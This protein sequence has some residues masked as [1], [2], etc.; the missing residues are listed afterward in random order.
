MDY[1][2]SQKTLRGSLKIMGIFVILIVVEAGFYRY[3]QMLKLIKLC[4]KYVPICSSIK[5]LL[6]M[7]NHFI[8]QEY[9]TGQG[10]NHGLQGHRK[11]S[12]STNPPLP[13][14]PP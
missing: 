5:L 9:N 10:N 6:K 13:N 14:A 11:R 7:K 8:F 4:L 1:Q 12:G 2:R 3:I